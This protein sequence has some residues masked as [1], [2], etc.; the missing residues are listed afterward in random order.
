[1]NASLWTLMSLI[2]MMEPKLVMCQNCGYS[3][4]EP[5]SRV[6]IPGYSAGSCVFNDLREMCYI[7][8]DMVGLW[9]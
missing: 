7:T 9:L 2:G 6:L 8:T 4:K 1:M 5:I 3:R